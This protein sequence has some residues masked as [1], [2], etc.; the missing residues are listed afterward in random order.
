MRKPVCAGIAAFFC[1][2][3]C[4]AA[5]RALPAQTQN[6]PSN[7]NANSS[8]ASTGSSATPAPASSAPQMAATQPAT[9]VWTNDDLSSLHG[10]GSVSNG[11]VRK[12]K[13]A[14]SAQPAKK[15]PPANP[16]QTQITKLQAQLPPINAQIADLQA[17]LSGQAVN[18][19]RKYIGVR[20]D[21]WQAELVDLQKKRADIQG[22]IDTLE[23]QARHAGV[24]TNALP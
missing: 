17:A 9:K 12:P 3:F 21:D 20:P 5:V 11:T 8:S 19:P 10:D 4:V 24:P 14:K 18:T 22:Q 15:N 16:Y 13:S 7:D 6:A 1:G 2:F 23:D